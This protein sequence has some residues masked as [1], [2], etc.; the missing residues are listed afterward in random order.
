VDEANGGAVMLSEL[1]A[2]AWTQPSDIYIKDVLNAARPILASDEKY[3]HL[4]SRSPR[5]DGRI[6]IQALSAM[7][8]MH[9][10]LTSDA[11]DA[12]SWSQPIRLT[13]GPAYWAQIQSLGGGRLVVIYNQVIDPASGED[14]VDASSSQTKTALFAR[15]SDDY[16]ASWGQP[17]RI[18]ST[19]NRVARSSLVTSPVDGTLILAW[20]EGYDNLTGQGEAAGIFTAISTDSGSTWDVAGRLDDLDPSERWASHA[21]RGSVEQSTLVATQT[22]AMLVYRATVDD[23]LLYR[24]SSDQGR[25]WSEEQEVPLAVPREFTGPH[26]FDKLGLAADGDGRIILV[27]VGQDEGTESGLSVQSMTFEEGTWSGPSV[28]AAPEGYPEYPRLTITHGNQVILTYFVRD[29]IYVDGGHYVIWTALGTTPARAVPPAPLPAASADGDNDIATPSEIRSEVEIMP[30]P[31]VSEE[32]EAVATSGPLESPSSTISR[33][34]MWA[35][36]LTIG[37]LAI[38]IVVFRSLKKLTGF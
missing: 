36:L 9:A 14:T 10:P 21:S 31:T 22:T 17:T 11:T 26:H 23:V 20:D 15:V 27:F 25:S 12:G 28:V 30:Y 37:F 5:P 33:P 32:T 8:Y 38:S 4:I 35:S 29:V 19:E 13:S 18:S 16:G 34:L 3:L 1:R 7:Y 6:T 24:L 2:G